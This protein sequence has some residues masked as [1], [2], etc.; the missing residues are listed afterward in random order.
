MSLGNTRTHYAVG[1]GYDYADVALVK[2]KYQLFLVLP[3]GKGSNNLDGKF[4]MDFF[5][6]RWTPLP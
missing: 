1:D 2:Q 6:R 5:I 3:L 4:K